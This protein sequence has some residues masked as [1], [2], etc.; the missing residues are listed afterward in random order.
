MFRVQRCSVCSLPSADLMLVLRSGT[1]ARP[2]SQFFPNSVHYATSQRRRLL[3]QGNNR[4]PKPSVYLSRTGAAC[5]VGVPSKVASRIHP[6][7]ASHRPSPPQVPARPV[8]SPAQDRGSGIRD[9]RAPVNCPRRGQRPPTSLNGLGR[10]DSAF[11]TSGS[12][13]RA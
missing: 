13:A 7:G 3:L 6:S 2:I 5:V 10:T 9:R 8:A 1:V 4:Q 12:H 11:R